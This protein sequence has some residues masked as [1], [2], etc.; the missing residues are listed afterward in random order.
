MNKVTQLLDMERLEQAATGRTGCQGLPSLRQ[1]PS[2]Q[3]LLQ[4]LHGVG[5]APRDLESHG[6]PPQGG[7][8]GGAGEGKRV[9]M[10]RALRQG[11]RVERKP[12]RGRCASRAGST[13]GREET[14]VLQ[15]L[16]SFAAAWRMIN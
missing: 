3:I 7:A 9:A 4:V 1:I 15:S 14:T 8:G 16:P 10:P 12:G 13:H 6:P 5:S 2:Q 11:Y